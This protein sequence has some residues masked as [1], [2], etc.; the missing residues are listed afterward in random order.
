MQGRAQMR[1]SCLPLINYDLERPPGPGLELANFGGATCHASPRCFNL[2]FS[3]I[4]RIIQ[5][6]EA[7][8]TLDNNL[9]EGEEGIEARC[10]ADSYG[11]R[12]NT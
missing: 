8:A 11:P 1:L 10:S 2:S 3:E 6:L 4:R 5:V 7:K 12:E 9:I